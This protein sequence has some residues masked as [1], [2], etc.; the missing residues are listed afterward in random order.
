[1]NNKP[2]LRD[3]RRQEA[4]EALYRAV[5]RRD[6][7]LDKLA[8]S[9]AH[10]KKLKRA[11]ARLDALDPNVISKVPVSVAEGRLLNELDEYEIT[12]Q[13]IKELDDDVSDVGRAS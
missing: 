10:I 1:M 9:I 8:R 5:E 6:L 7:L 2:S 13:M 3:R 12:T 11:L 4:R